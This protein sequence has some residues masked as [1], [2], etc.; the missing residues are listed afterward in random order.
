MKIEANTPRQ[1]MIV[2]ASNGEQPDE[3]LPTSTR[4]STR[5][6][7]NT[8]RLRRLLSGETLWVSVGSSIF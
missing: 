1:K 4:S 7:E 3:Q 6:L 2:Q 8:G 5:R